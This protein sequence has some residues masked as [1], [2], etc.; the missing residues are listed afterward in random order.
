MQTIIY[1]SET[2][3]FGILCVLLKVEPF[4]TDVLCFFNKTKKL[5]ARRKI[6]K[7]IYLTVRMLT[8][9]E[10]FVFLENLNYNGD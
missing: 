6:C 10:S 1:N 5:F 3:D 9:Y 7:Q 8:S 2:C 4:T